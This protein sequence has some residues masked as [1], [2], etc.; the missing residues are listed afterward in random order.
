MFPQTLDF[1]G[2]FSPV[3]MIFSL[4]VFD[5]MIKKFKGLN[6]MFLYHM[7]AVS[8]KL[9]YLFLD[10]RNTSLF[11]WITMWLILGKITLVWVRTFDRFVSLWL[12]F[13]I[14]HALFADNVADNWHLDVVGSCGELKIQKSN[15]TS[16]S[17]KKMFGFLI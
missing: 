6:Y 7:L 1:P 3:F 8:N 17:G 13:L 14:L 11:H 16:L 12:R 2:T 5:F 15:I 10:I 4:N 9:W